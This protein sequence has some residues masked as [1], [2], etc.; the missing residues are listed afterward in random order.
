M[1]REAKEFIE[2]AKGLPPEEEILLFE[3]LAK[4]RKRESDRLLIELFSSRSVW[5]RERV[6]DAVWEFGGLLTARKVARI[7]V[8]DRNFGVRNAAVEALGEVGTTRDARSLIH[9]LETDSEWVIRASAASSLGEIRSRPGVEALRLAVAADRNWCVRAYAADALCRTHDRSHLDLMRQRLE[10]E[11]EPATKVAILHGLVLLGEERYLEAIIDIL[12]EPSHWY[13][14][15]LRACAAL[16]EG[17][18]EAGMAVPSRLISAL[19]RVLTYDVGRAA[20]SAAQ[21]LLDKLN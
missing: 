18:L 5:L 17:F 20:N 6:L 10:A 12:E 19:Q 7:G 16:D 15:Y 8:Q 2:I 21:E 4:A 11:P 9:V 14:V 13:I 1:T 3:N